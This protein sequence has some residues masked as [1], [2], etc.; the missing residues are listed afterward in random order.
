MMI[1]MGRFIGLNSTGLIGL[2]KKQGR[3]PLAFMMIV[4]KTTEKNT[5]S[6]AKQVLKSVIWYLDFPADLVS[7]SA[8]R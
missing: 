1:L 5:H 7:R 2:V 8:F 3:V 6:S 4:D